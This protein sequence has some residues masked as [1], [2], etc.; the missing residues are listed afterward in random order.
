VVVRGGGFPEN[1]EELG[2]PLPLEEAESRTAQST[3]QP[4]EERGAATGGG[5]HLGAAGVVVVVVVVGCCCLVGVESEFDESLEECLDD[6][7]D[8][9]SVELVTLYRLPRSSP[10]VSA[11]TT[12]SQPAI[13][14][15][16]CASDWIARSVASCDSRV[17]AAQPSLSVQQK[18]PRSTASRSVDSTQ[19]DVVTPA[20]TRCV[21]PRR[22]S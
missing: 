13:Q 12:S 7:D 22:R 21:T 6:D 5:G 3:R 18:N 8:D 1:V 9:G 11:A 19:H 2:P 14:P 4:L 16:M 20:N 15:K 10:F 17:G